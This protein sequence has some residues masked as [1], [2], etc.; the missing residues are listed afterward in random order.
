MRIKGAKRRGI[1]CRCFWGWA[2]DPGLCFVFVFLVVLLKNESKE[3][4]RQ[5]LM[6]AA[7]KS[8]RVAAF[9]WAGTPPETSQHGTGTFKE[10]HKWQPYLSQVGLSHK[11]PIPFPAYLG[12]P[13]GR[14]KDRA[15]IWEDMCLLYLRGW[16]YLKGKLKLLDWTKLYFF[17]L[18]ILLYLLTF[19]LFLWHAEIPRSGIT[20]VTTLDP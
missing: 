14:T 2:R 18:T 6:A 11:P 13:L 1:Q 19:R 17:F 5:L 8:G 7:S 20:A 4:P 3:R 16:H 12:D 9:R 10:Q 15:A